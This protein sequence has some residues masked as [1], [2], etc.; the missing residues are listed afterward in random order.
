MPLPPGPLEYVPGQSRVR[1]WAGWIALY[2]A[3]FTLGWY[4]SLA[5]LAYFLG[6]AAYSPLQL[7]IAQLTVM[8]PIFMIGIVLY[9]ILVPMPAPGLWLNPGGVAL[10]QGARHQFVPAVRLHISG[11]RLFI[12]PKR[13]TFATGY[14][15]TPYQAWRIRTVLSTGG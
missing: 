15:I 13:F 7:L 2:V 11:N 4:V 5:V 3:G 14:T 8:L 9:G 10:E 6:G 1:W 12:L